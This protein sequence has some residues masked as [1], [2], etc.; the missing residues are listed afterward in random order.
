MDV[1]DKQ[2]V[3]L[4]QRDGNLSYQEIG[5]QIDLS[6]TAVKE[7]IKK[8]KQDEVLR[9]KV[10]LANPLAFGLDILAFVYVLMP[11]PSQE[12]HF[13]EE[14]RKVPEV[15][16]CHSVTGEYSYLLKVRVPNTMRLEEF[17]SEKI[18]SIEGVE[19]TNSLITL[20]TFKETTQIHIH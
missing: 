6:I 14:I 13:I 17:M 12:R 2:I 11:I 4:L 1:K 9:E 18:T 7:R 19:R 10:Y 8:L 3:D 16:E 5:N 20:T 15:Q